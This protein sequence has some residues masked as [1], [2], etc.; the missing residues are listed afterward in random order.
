M[1]SN[2]R[3]IAICDTCG[4]QYPHRVLKKNSYG[5][6]VC[7]TD[8]EGQFDLKNHPQNRAANTF[9]DPSIRDPRPPLND[10]RN[11]LWNNAT[12]N[13]ENETSNWNNV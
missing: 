12:V 7:P 1:A 11:V 9:D 3:A 13:W 10:D 4:F 5:M 2:K 8:W 6:L